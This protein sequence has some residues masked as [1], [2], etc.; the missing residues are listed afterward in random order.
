MFFCLF[1]GRADYRCECPRGERPLV[2][3]G[4]PATYS[5]GLRG[6][7]CRAVS[8]GQPGTK[9]SYKGTLRG[10]L[11]LG[12]DSRERGCKPSVVVGVVDDVGDDPT[13]NVDKMVREHYKDP[14][15]FGIHISQLETLSPE[16][17]KENR[18][19]DGSIIADMF[20]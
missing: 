9:R 19:A 14:S 2:R 18:P 15:H 4:R 10:G 17:V 11:K 12:D 8:Q 3:G 6:T 16:G 7:V 13:V 5:R 20:D 1:P